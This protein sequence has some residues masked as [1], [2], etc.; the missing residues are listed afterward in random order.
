MND[1]EPRIDGPR[2]DGES[3]VERLESWLTAAATADAI[4]DVFRDG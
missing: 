2:I 3:D 4:A 1:P